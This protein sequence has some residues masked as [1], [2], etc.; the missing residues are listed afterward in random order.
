MPAHFLHSIGKRRNGIKMWK[1]FN[2]CFNCLPVAAIVS[3]KIFCCHG[4]LS[5]ELKEFQQI[6]KM[7]RPTDVP[8]S[9]VCDKLLSVSV[10]HLCVILI[11]VF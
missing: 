1:K 5:P 6:R 11:C 7:D 9:G 2:D 4:G 10:M 3:D 8:D